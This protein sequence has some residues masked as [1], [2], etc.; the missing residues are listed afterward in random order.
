MALVTG[1]DA[2][3]SR[4]ACLWCKCPE[5]ERHRMDLEWSLVDIVKGART[6]EE[7][8]TNS[9]H[10]KS[11]KKYNVS[12]R[13]LFPTIP[14]KRV[15]IDPHHLFLRV[16][17]NLINLLITELRRLDVLNH[18]HYTDKGSYQYRY[19][20]FFNEK[21]SIPFKWTTSQNATG[22]QWR[23]LTGPEKQR[24]FN[25][26]NIPELFPELPNNVVINKLWKDFLT[27][28]KRIQEEDTVPEDFKVGAQ[29]W[30]S[31]YLTLYQTKNVT[32]YIHAFAMHVWEFIKL[33]GSLE[34][35]SQQGLEKLNDLTTLHYLRATNHHH[36]NDEALRQLILKRNWIEKLEDNGA[37]RVKRSCTCSKC[38]TKGHNKIGCPQLV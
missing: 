9:T 30:V 4:Y 34:P 8:L 3:N 21:F 19:E 36:K 14:L 15:V 1:I 33:Y 16:T 6:I 23:D 7:T 31:L 25:T 24:L 22:V 28:S 12:S 5:E 27:L 2:A 20:L 10:P 38:G 35:Y 26:I 29:S 11:R 17:D 18:S 37:K 13:P 32:P